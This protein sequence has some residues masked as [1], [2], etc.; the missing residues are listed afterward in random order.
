MGHP[1]ALFFTLL[2]FY[3]IWR[4]EKNQH[5]LR[6]GLSGGLALGML[7]A[8]RPT[9]ALTIGI[10]LAVYSAGRLLLSLKKHRKK[11]G[12]LLIGE[13]QWWMR[14][15]ILW[16]P[17]LLLSGGLAYLL[18]DTYTHWSKLYLMITVIG[19]LTSAL[20]YAV[21]EDKTRVNPPLPSQFWP[22]LYPLLAVFI[23]TI[24]LA[25]LYPAFNYAAT[26]NP[27][28][29]LYTYI[30][31]YDTLGVGNGHGYPRQATVTDPIPTG[32]KIALLQY[33]TWDQAKQNLQEDMTCYSRDLF[34]WVAQPDN[35][36][37]AIRSNFP[38]DLCAVDRAGYSWVLLPVGLIFGWRRRWTYVF[39]FSALSIIGITL[40]Y[41][42]GAAT[43]SA[44]YYYEA[45]GIFALISAVG[46]AGIIH[47]VKQWH[48]D[49][50]IYVLISLIAIQT[51][52]GYAPRRLQPIEMQFTA[53][54]RRQLA[55]AEALH[56]N[57]E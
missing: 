36:P 32:G 3:S 53:N 14:A 46:V 34:G 26:G 38:Q 45:T 54:M 9:N 50:I 18:I 27:T 8:I 39:M 20:A 4:L 30:W 5:T 35:P 48:L 10:P 51:A 55:E 25:A 22:T 2:T 52:F 33:H 19:M 23:G 12:S 7:F 24:M 1:A 44:R 47:H 57:P 11:S 15:I 42:I 21:F 49:I 28:D 29:N 43:Y 40:F 41:W 37:T 56:P 13:T 16:L 17:I 6:W 31:E